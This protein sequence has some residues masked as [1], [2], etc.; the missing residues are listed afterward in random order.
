MYNTVGDVESSAHAQGKLQPVYAVPNKPDKRRTVHTSVSRDSQPTPVT[1]LYSQVNKGKKQRTNSQSKRRQQ[2]KDKRHSEYDNIEIVD[3]GEARDVHAQQGARP[4]TTIQVSASNN[5]DSQSNSSSQTAIRHQLSNAR[6]KN[7]NT[8]PG[9]QTI[10]SVEHY[11]LDGVDEDPDY[12]TVVDQPTAVIL[13][14]ADGY[15]LDDYESLPGSAAAMAMRLDNAGTSARATNAAAV[16]TDASNHSDATLTAAATH[17]ESLARTLP[18][19]NNAIT[20]TSNDRNANA[21]PVEGLIHISQHQPRSQPYQRREHIYEQ[22]SD[23]ENHEN[24]Y[25]ADPT[26]HITIRQKKVAPTQYQVV[27]NL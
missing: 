25:T 9:Y 7:Q 17:L 21:E 13:G 6:E 1:E 16:A 19:S 24:I 20:T 26:R 5:R 12:D 2:Q 3:S 18:D 23:A 10:G 4:K 11:P 15:D 27:T 14:G 8:A 22:I